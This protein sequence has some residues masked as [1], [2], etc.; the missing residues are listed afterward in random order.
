MEAFQCCRN[1]CLDQVSPQERVQQC[2][3]HCMKPLADTEQFVSQEMEKFQVAYTVAS[4][5]KVLS[6]L[7]NFIQSIA[8]D[9][10]NLPYNLTKYSINTSTG[11]QWNQVGFVTSL[12]GLLVLGPI[13]SMWRTVCR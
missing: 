11:Y 2:I 4:F 1:C 5:V 9:K 10:I 7:N 8:R 6:T 12:Y 13:Y 3:Q